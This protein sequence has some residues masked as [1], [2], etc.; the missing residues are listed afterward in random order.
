MFAELS[1]RMIKGAFCVYFIG[2]LT[3]F[4]TS[5][6]FICAEASVCFDMAGLDEIWI[7]NAGRAGEA[8][9]LY[10]VTIGSLVYIGPRGPT[11]QLLL[12]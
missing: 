4:V 9:P 6:V 1:Y 12:I 7:R 8:V 11:S 5:I 10:P 3:W 2:Y